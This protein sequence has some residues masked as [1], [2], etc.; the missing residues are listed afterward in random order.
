[1]L[2]IHV[3]VRVDRLPMPGILAHLDFHLFGKNPSIVAGGELGRAHQRDR[4]DLGLQGKVDADPLQAPIRHGAA[5]TAPDGIRV[6]V[7][8]MDGQQR[9]GVVLWGPSRNLRLRPVVVVLDLPGLL[10]LDLR[11]RVRVAFLHL[12]PGAQVGALTVDIHDVVERIDRNAVADALDGGEV[13]H[14]GRRLPGDATGG[15]AGKQRRGANA[16]MR[17]AE[18]AVRRQTAKTIIAFASSMAEDA[19]F[20]CSGRPTLPAR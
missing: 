12:E 10:E 15:Q 5:P 13:L 11:H 16:G 19:M 1:M 8:Q 17:P 4:R 18:H 9:L 7:D 14:F 6:A 2:G 20:V 3:L